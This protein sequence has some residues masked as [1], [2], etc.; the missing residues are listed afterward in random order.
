[1]AAPEEGT[2]S[3][4]SLPCGAGFQPALVGAADE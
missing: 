2:S 3:Q 1:M 4:R